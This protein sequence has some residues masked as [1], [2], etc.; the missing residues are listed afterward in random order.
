MQGKFVICKGSAGMGNRILAASTAALYAQIAGRN[1]VVDWRDGSYSKDGINAFYEFF[2]Q[3]NDTKI[4]DLSN[5]VSVYP[6]LWVGKL[7]QSFSSLQSELGQVPDRTLSFDL[8]KLDYEE[9]ILVFFSYTHKVHKM[10]SLFQGDFSHLSRLENR[11]VLKFVLDSHFHLKDDIRQAVDSFKAANFGAKTVGVH[12]RQTDMVI[13][14]EQLIRTTKSIVK[15]RKSDCI[16]LA[17]DNRKII[18]LF[19]QEFDRV[20]IT[21]KWF[22]AP[23]ETMHQNW[24]AC[25]DLIQNGKEALVDLYLLAECGDLVF[26]PKSSFGYLASILSKVPS[27]SYLH[28]V[29]KG[30]F[31]ERLK[32]SILRKLK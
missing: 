27:Q 9:D 21:P 6:S 25:P 31:M 18:D 20:V 15:R 17:T 22:P 29:T 28:D 5:S 8:S 26:S 32:K 4:S 10:R 3:T 24:D 1:L 30:S 13:P 11:E 19:N 16:F 7:D 2:K 23:G 14:L 12:V